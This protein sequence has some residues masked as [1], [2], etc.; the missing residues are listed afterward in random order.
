MSFYKKNTIKS[1]K[2]TVTA[3]RYKLQKTE[4]SFASCEH[5]RNI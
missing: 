3:K 5:C 1:A 4:E 2:V